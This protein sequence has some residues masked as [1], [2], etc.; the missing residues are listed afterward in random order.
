ML[1][2]SESDLLGYCRE[3]VQLGKIRE[4][5][6]RCAAKETPHTFLFPFCV[7]SIFH[8]VFKIRIQLILHDRNA[9]VSF[10]VAIS[11]PA[12]PEHPRCRM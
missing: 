5:L 9:S 3:T 10:F 12:S 7:F 11:F 4:L 8:L 6:S 2:H 1:L